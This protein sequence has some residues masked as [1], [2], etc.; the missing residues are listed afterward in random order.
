MTVLAFAAAALVAMLGALHL[1]Y[2]LIDFGPRPRYFRPTDL[3]LLE[4]MQSAKTAIAPAGRDYWSGVLGFNLS[5][6]IGVMLL[7]LLIAI[8]TV[9]EI[10][11]LKPV[12]VS[13]G[14]TYAIISYRCWFHIPTICILLATALMIAGWWA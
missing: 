9:Y 4:S 7:A 3:A 14:I 8:A 2:T 10:A 12:L 11:W 1:A 13:V 5:H 6:S